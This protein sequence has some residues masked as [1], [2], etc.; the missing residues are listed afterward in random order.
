MEYRPNSPTVFSTLKAAGYCDESADSNQY[1][2]EQQATINGTSYTLS[3][4]AKVDANTFAY[5]IDNI[6]SRMNPFIWDLYAKYAVNCL[7]ALRLANKEDLQ[8][9]KG[10]TAK[11]NELDSLLFNARQFYDP[12][13]AGSPRAKWDRVI[14]SV[15]SKYFFIDSSGAAAKTLSLYESMIWLGWYNPLADPCADSF[16]ITLNTDVFDVQDLDFE[17]INGENG[18]PIIEFKEPFIV[19]PNEAAMLKVYYYRTGTDG[20]RPIGLWFEEAKNLRDLTDVLL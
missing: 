2:E 4:L 15:G 7:A 10:A 11:G 13:S 19:P 9:Y 14:S 5:E 8:G 1:I 3:R 16:Q 12:D 18:E 20:M 6:L 17:K